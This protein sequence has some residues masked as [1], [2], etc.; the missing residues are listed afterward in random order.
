[1][2]KQFMPDVSPGHRLQ[3]LQ[4]NCDSQETTS[5][6]RDLSQEELDIKREQL[7]ENLIQ[8]SNLEEELSEIK[9]RFTEKLSPMKTQRK[10]ML[11]A[12]KMRKEEVKGTLFHI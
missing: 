7:S 4:E 9:K 2:S 6:L 11:Q 5:Y 10:E 1:M 8:A 12:I 3:L